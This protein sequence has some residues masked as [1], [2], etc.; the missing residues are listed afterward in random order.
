MFSRLLILAATFALA[1]FAA[2][3]QQSQRPSTCLAIAQ[4]LPD[5]VYASF[6]PAAASDEVEITYAGHSTYVIVTP[7]GIRIATDFNGYFGSDPVPDVVTMNKAHSTHYTPYP[8]PAIKHVLP[9]WGVDGEPAQHSVVVEDVYIRNVPTDIR[10]FGY[11]E[12]NGNSIFIFEVAGLCIGHLGHLHHPLDDTHY[13]AIGR[14]DI[15]MVP[16]DGG[17]TLSLEHMSE[18]TRRLQ[19]SIVLPMHR[20]ST[21]LNAFT[22]RLKDGFD[23]DFRNSPSMTVSVRSLPRRPTVVILQGV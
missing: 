1:P 20:H 5:V 12:K 2:Q 21:P 3:A 23:I 8:D 13:A 18:I 19:S 6:S 11:T 22:G 14:L 7:A 10:R 17:L 4:R 9:G 16:I 15:L